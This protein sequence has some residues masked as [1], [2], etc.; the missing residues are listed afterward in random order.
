MERSSWKKAL[1][2]FVV[3]GLIAVLCFG[4][5]WLYSLL[6]QPPQETPS[7]AAEPE[8]PGFTQEE[9]AQYSSSA[10]ED[11]L[12]KIGSGSVVTPQQFGALADGVHDDAPALQAALESGKA[13]VLISD[14]YL[15]SDVSIWD[16]DVDLNGN[17]YV[18]YLNDCI[19]E[20][21]ALRREEPGGDAAVYSEEQPFYGTYRR[22]YVSYHGSC[23]LAEPLEDYSVSYFNEH[24]AYISNVVLLYRGSGDACALTLKR[25]C[26][27]LLR[28][29]SVLCEKGSDGEV[30]ILLYHCYQTRLE[31]CYAQNWTASS[32]GNRGYGIEAFGEDISLEGCAAYGNKHDICLCSGRDIISNNITVKNCRVGCQYDPSATR[33]DGS[34]TYLARFDIHAAGQNVRVENLNISVENANAGTV[35]ACLRC[36]EV[37]VEGLTIQGEA[38]YID[39]GELAHSVTFRDLQM[40]NIKIHGGFAPEQSV[41]ELSIQ[42]GCIAGFEALR[43]DTQVHLENVTLTEESAAAPVQGE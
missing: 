29:V 39:F 26:K 36:P 17:G 8:A 1:L 6:K 15:F 10:G 37:T 7:E 11:P 16:Y 13:V 35:Y 14:L 19:M 18:L 12:T 34:R 25:L 3:V 21:C 38:G 41:K 32:T 42:N 30:G 28:N 20:V 4:G 9:V 22:G 2:P 40:P 23:P 43:P 27:S 5:P 31:N 24:R 33:D